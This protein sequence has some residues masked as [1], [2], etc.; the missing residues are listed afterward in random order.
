M[1][2]LIAVFF[3]AGN[4]M[5]T[6]GVNIPIE[7]EKDSEK[8][9]SSTTENLFRWAEDLYL[10]KGIKVTLQEPAKNAEIKKLSLFYKREKELKEFFKEE[11]IDFS[12]IS[13]TYENES[14]KG[15]PVINIEIAAYEI[16]A[17]IIRP[18]SVFMNKNALL[19]TC[20]PEDFELA[21]TL[22][23]YSLS[24]QEEM[25]NTNVSS[26]FENKIILIR[27][28]IK[29]E[30]LNG[31]VPNKP[32]T[33]QLPINVSE[34]K[35][36]LLLQWNNINREWSKTGTTIRVTS[37][38][39]QQFFTAI[40]E[41]S[42]IYA[43]AESKSVSVFP[44]AATAPKNAAITYIELISSDP[45]V[46]IEGTISDNQKE[47]SFRAPKN[48][49]DFIIRAVCEDASGKEWVEET[50][51]KKKTLLSFLGNKKKLN[52]YFNQ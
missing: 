12:R 1:K 37:K 33:A 25:Y 5:L 26:Y 42:G 23:H 31:R 20:K 6:Q 47:A 19:I 52:V 18:D 46:R 22:S 38:K 35:S 14:N 10:A 2:K 11:H 8:F 28:L 24:S 43:L 49:S 48:H 17:E 39:G 3:F 44:V 16:T 4:I 41:E 15:F 7:F 32:V 29:I 36:Y 13:Y 34:K 51:A 21:N 50:K 45:F 30:F 9:T 27:E 40:I